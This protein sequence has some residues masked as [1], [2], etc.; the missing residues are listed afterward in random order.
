MKFIISARAINYAAAETYCDG[1][2]NCATHNVALTTSHG[3]DGLTQLD[4]LAPGS[5][6]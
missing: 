5:F 4:R 6:P 1:T 3:F 2:G